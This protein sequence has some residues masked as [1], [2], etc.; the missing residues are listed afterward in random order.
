MDLSVTYLSILQDTLDK[1]MQV[2]N[3]IFVVTKQQEQFLKLDEVQTEALDR[4]MDQKSE[5]LKKLNEL[6]D[7]F[8]KLY[9]KV[10]QQLQEAP[11]AYA[12]Q[13]ALLKQS[14]SG[15]M[16]L[17]VSIEALERKNKLA[18]ERY[19][20][21]HR[22]NIHTYKTSQKKVNAYYN[23]MTKFSPHQ[24]YFMDKKK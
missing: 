19:F 10:R 16:D 1:K 14:I 22:K 7:G 6:D 8:E 20:I 5:Y 15:I 21:R 18:M 23:T 4:T 17:S 12:Q 9:A 24:S 2:L 3:D 13:I 11:G